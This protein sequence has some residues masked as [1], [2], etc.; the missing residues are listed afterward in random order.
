MRGHDGREE[1]VRYRQWALEIADVLAVV[2]M[3]LKYRSAKGF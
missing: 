1:A 3:A 2:V